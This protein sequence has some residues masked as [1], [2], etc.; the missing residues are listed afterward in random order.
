MGQQEIV[1]KNLVL[2]P[3]GPS[4]ILKDESHLQFRL[5]QTKYYFLIYG[6]YNNT[7]MIESQ[8]MEY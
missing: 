1:K 6:S 7:E 2:M 8:I 5:R 4:K 3:T